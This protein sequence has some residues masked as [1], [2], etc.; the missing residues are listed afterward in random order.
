VAIPFPFI[1]VVW[2][3]FAGAGVEIRYVYPALAICGFSVVWSWVIAP[4]LLPGR[5]PA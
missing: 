5:L 4:R 1:H 3:V 2:T